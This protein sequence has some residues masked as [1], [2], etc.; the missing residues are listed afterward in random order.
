MD[1]GLD[2]SAPWQPDRS[3]LSSIARQF[4]FGDEAGGEIIGFSALPTGHINVTV[5]VTTAAA[6]RFILQRINQVVFVDV[7]GLM[8]NIVRVTEH[9][10]RSG[11]P[12][13]RLVPTLA[14]EHF[15]RDPQSGDCW[16]AFPLIEGSSCVG[17]TGSTAQAEQAAFAFGEFAKALSDLPGSRLHSVI[18]D[19]HNTPKRF[20]D[21][22]SAVDQDPLGRTAGARPEI[23]AAQAGAA[24]MGQV[25]ASMADAGV[26]ERIAHNDAKLDNVLF[27]AEGRRAIC[28]VDLDTVMPGSLLHDFGDLVRS[29]AATAGEDERD[30]ARVGVS[31]GRFAALARGY[32]AA[33]AD[34]MTDGE[35]ALLPLAGRLIAYEQA[36]RFLTDHLLGDP[37]YR[38]RYQGH[39][40]ERARNQL[41]LTASLAREEPALTEICL[42]AA[43]SA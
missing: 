42:Q 34:A 36:L 23:A 30:P 40:L 41:A 31:R 43:R 17:T 21:F 7:A 16:R 27:D 13:L 9:L 32:I 14:G 6:G 37:Y 35:H 39:N 1:G 38:I 28:V 25:C 12:G 8:E 29:A 10:H 26:P 4:E 22:L 33:W 5:I 15:Y 18:P 20:D 2:G 3:A 24:W 19:F 11:L